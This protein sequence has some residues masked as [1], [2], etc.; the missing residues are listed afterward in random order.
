MR[1]FWFWRKPVIEPDT[2]CDIC[3]HR[4]VDHNARVKN[5]H[6]EYAIKGCGVIEI[7]N[8]PYPPW[9]ME[10]VEAG[11]HKPCRCTWDGRSRQK[12]IKS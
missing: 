9:T 7:A 2:P 1:P 3:K 8:G 4:A 11:Q 10:S 12:E 6:G 5:K